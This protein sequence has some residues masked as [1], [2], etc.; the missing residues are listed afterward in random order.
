MDLIDRR[1]PYDFGYTP[2]TVEGEPE[3]DTMMDFGIL[4]LRAGEEHALVTEKKLLTSC[5]LVPLPLRST[6]K[7]Q[8]NKN[9]A[10]PRILPVCMYLRVPM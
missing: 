10:I 4:K 2:I 8:S 7:K 5:L 9:I 6:E 1:E 3:N